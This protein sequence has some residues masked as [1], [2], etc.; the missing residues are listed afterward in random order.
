M[1]LSQPTRFTFSPSLHCGGERAAG[2][3]LRHHLPLHL[4]VS[5]AIPRPL[6]PSRE[7]LPPPPDVA[8]TPLEKQ[9]GCG[10]RDAERRDAGCGA[11]RGAGRRGA[12]S[13]LLQRCRPS[14]NGRRT[15]MCREIWKPP[16]PG[17]A[18]VPAG[19]GAQGRDGE[20]RGRWLQRVSL[21]QIH[22]CRFC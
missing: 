3:G 6:L 17:W 10:M 8:S 18:L 9:P 12:G 19:W 14:Q 13:G 20:H 1:F 2:V 5:P 11:S 21:V 4:R 15:R 22:T 7:S 16:C